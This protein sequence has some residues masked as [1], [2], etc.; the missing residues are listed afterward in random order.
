MIN[1][2]KE[3]LEKRLKVINDLFNQ[4]DKSNINSSELINEM[5]EIEFKLNKENIKFN[6][7]SKEKY[8]WA[9]QCAEFT[10]NV[11][12]HGFGW[13]T[14][15]EIKAKGVCFNKYSINNGYNQYCN[16]LKRFNSKEE[17]LGFVK[18]YN[19]AI[20]HYPPQLR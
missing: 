2:Q 1:K 4:G 5:H 11:F 3:K 16:D 18:G 14:K 10:K 15:E 12:E 9:Y 6:L 13:T 8:Y 20:K 7:R 19:E 17:M